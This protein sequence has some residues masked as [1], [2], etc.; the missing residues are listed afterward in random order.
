M[1]KSTAE[2]TNTEVQE[3]TIGQELGFIPL[4]NEEETTEETEA[5][6]T[7]PATE[8]PVEETKT[9]EAEYL[10]IEE[11]GDKM[12]KLKIN[13]EESTIT[14]KDALR[15][16]QTDKHLTQEG[17][18]L[19]EARRQFDELKN[20]VVDKSTEVKTE[21]DPY[22]TSYEDESTV[23]PDIADLKAQIAT[24]TDAVGS[25][26]QNLAPTVYEQ[27]VKAIDTYLRESEG[28]EE[29]HLIGVFE[30]NLS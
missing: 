26:K 7:E 11:L 4:D 21:T 17:Q 6:E 12:F 14:V 29:S 15:R 18:R 13:G 9:E 19:A 2:A 10:N 24:L 16:I 23:N 25:V 3:P 30:V 5:I 8:E 20:S 22:D 1:S 28:V 27:N